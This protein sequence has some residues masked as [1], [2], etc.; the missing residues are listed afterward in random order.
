MESSLQVATIQVL[1]SS[2]NELRVLS[3]QYYIEPSKELYNKLF[4]K[5]CVISKL[6][7]TDA[8]ISY[9]IL[10]LLHTMCILQND[11]LADLE[12][13][14]VFLD[15]AVLIEYNDEMFARFNAIL[16]ITTTPAISLLLEDYSNSVDVSHNEAI[17]ILMS[18]C[19][20]CDDIMISYFVSNM[21]DCDI[22]INKIDIEVDLLK[23]II[24]DVLISEDISSR[25]T[26]NYIKDTMLL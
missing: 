18:R 13:S 23:I 24:N 16:T 12:I 26:I 15:D 7:T 10:V 14:K 5:M 3:R 4:A 9:D 22:C 21:A 19:K 6:V 2:I 25:M 1:D 20:L 11:M 17:D 8:V